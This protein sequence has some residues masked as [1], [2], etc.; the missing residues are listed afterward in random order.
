MI[1]LA[2]FCLRLLLPWWHTCCCSVLAW[3]VSL[4]S[5]PFAKWPASHPAHYELNLY[6]LWAGIKPFHLQLCILGIL[7]KQWENNLAISYETGKW[8]YRRDGGERAPEKAMWIV[9]YIEWYSS[10]LQFSQYHTIFKLISRTDIWAWTEC[11]ASE[12][13]ECWEYSRMEHCII[14]IRVWG[15]K[16][17]PIRCEAMRLGIK[18]AG[19]PMA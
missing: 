19:P 15:L 9:E 11:T 13:P 8:K 18:Q 17:S 1:S 5:C 6:E 10:L 7:S 2:I 12:V 3:M 16:G 14:G 4:L